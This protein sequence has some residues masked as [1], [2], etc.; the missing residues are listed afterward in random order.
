MNL[1]MSLSA[2]DFPPARD[3]ADVAISGG[4]AGSRF[5]AGKKKKPN[6]EIARR[7]TRDATR[8]DARPPRAPS[9]PRPVRPHRDYAADDA[10]RSLFRSSL[11]QSKMLK[12]AGNDDII[13]MKADDAGDVV[14]FMF[15]SPGATLPSVLRVAPDISRRARRTAIEARRAVA[16]VASRRSRRVSSRAHEALF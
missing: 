10:P 16:R 13:T 2:G 7:G 1:A 14:T 15:E 8:R 12:C 6:I 5:L 3:V 11:A 9:R 4:G